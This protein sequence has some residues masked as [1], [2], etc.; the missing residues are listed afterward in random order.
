M[1]KEQHFR[2]P[3]QGDEWR[4]Y[5]G[6]YDSLYTI[7][8]MARDEDGNAVVVY[9]PS[10]W[11]LA[12]AP[13]VYTRRLADFIMEIDTGKDIHGRNNKTPRF[14]CERPTP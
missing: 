1:S 5:K 11:T 7:V 14:V 9:M 2:M 6:G 8:S 13:P 3:A 4:H 10:G 12:Q